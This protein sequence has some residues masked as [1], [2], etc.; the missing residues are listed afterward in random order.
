MDTSKELNF[1]FENRPYEF[2][3]LESGTKLRLQ[4]NEIKQVC[5]ED[6]SIS[7][8]IAVENHAI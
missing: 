2:I 8:R 1:E 4:S 5:H 7:G 3:D 6:E